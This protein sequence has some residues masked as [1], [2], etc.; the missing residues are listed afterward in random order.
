MNVVGLVELA[1]PETLAELG[2]QVHVNK[3]PAT[4]EVR[5]MLVAVL[6]HCD[7]AGGEFD[8]SG[9]GYTVTI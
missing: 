1:N 6:L 3:V 4:C 9:N 2:V 5:V 7:L 8:R